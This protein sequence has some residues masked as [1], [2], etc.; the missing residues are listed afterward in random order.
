MSS[1]SSDVIELLPPN[2]NGD[3]EPAKNADVSY[4][5][6]GSQTSLGIGDDIDAGVRRAGAK[7]K[8]QPRTELIKVC[9]VCITDF[10]SY[11]LK[12]YTM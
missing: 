5:R 12:Q 10:S 6:D 7:G 9:Y 1:P 11:K 4:H 3:S 2:Q 8:R